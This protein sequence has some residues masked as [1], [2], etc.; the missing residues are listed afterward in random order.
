MPRL[1]PGSERR[2]AA[3][4]GRQIGNTPRTPRHPMTVAKC[5][6]NPT[7]R[8]PNERARPPNNRG[9]AGNRDSVTLG[10]VCALALSRNLQIVENKCTTQLAPSGCE[11]NRFRSLLSPTRTIANI[12]K[13]RVGKIRKDHELRRGREGRSQTRVTGVQND[14]FPRNPHSG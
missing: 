2:S 13:A 10:T 4:Q 12:T 14:G 7:S 8:S 5:P 11:V 6:P 1:H 9:T 3:T